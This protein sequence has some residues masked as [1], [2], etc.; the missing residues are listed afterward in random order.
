MSG[1]NYSTVTLLVGAADRGD[2]S[3]ADVLFSTLYSELHRLAKRELARQSLPV[4]LSATTLLHQAYLGMAEREGPSFPDCARF[5]GYAARVMRGLIIDHARNRQA[6]KRGGQFE[7][8]SL[9]T[10]DPDGSADYQELK[11]IS[12]TLEDLARVDPA[13][14]EIVDLKFFCGFSFTEIAAMRAVSERTVQRNWE[15]ARIYLH[16]KLRSDLSL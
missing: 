4:T 14:A 16:R 3:A 2:R 9:G 15:K 11:N 10:D 1:A 12:D 13:L 5:M 6:Q 8:T 7:I